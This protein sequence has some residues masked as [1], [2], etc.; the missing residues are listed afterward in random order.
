MGLTRQGAA[1][2]NSISEVQSS[3]EWWTGGP[4]TRA[5]APLG[6]PQSQGAGVTG[7]NMRIQTLSEDLV[8]P[9]SHWLS[10]CL[11][12]QFEKTRLRELYRRLRDEEQ[13]DF[14]H[15]KSSLATS[16]MIRLSS[17]W[18]CMFRVEKMTPSNSPNAVHGYMLVLS[19][20][21]AADPNGLVRSYCDFGCGE[22]TNAK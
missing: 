16:S 7:E 12:I 17:G 9:S 13:R 5:I 11:R 15:V 22:V 10:Q 1:S 2:Y 3:G 8:S 19:V 6:L 20:L 4:R 14:Y 18:S 21:H